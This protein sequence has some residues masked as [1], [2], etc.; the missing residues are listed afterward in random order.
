MSEP[1]VFISHFRVRTGKA[2]VIE[3]HDAGGH[4]T[5]H[6]L[7][8]GAIELRLEL[9]WACPFERRHQWRTRGRSTDRRPAAV[10]SNGGAPAD[11]PSP[12]R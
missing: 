9:E 4:A 7:T 10:R 8:D 12:R 5:V 6:G 1:I 3:G 11:S 2:G